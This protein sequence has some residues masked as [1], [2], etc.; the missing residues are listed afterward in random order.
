MLRAPPA[1]HSIR[2]KLSAIVVSAAALVPA[3]VR[4]DSLPAKGRTGEVHIAP[5]QNGRIGAW[6]VVGPFHSA[7]FGDRKKPPTP[8]AL[9][10]PPVGVDESHILPRAGFPIGPT[11]SPTPTPDSTPTPT[12]P[13]TPPPPSPH[14]KPPPLWTLA[15]SN[16]GSIDLQS[17]LHTS[18]PDV[19]AYAAGTLR[20]PRAGRYYILVGADDGVRVY[21]NGRPVFLRD[22]ARPEREDDD[23]IP[24]NLSAGAHPLL[25]KLH[26]R[27][28]GWR[29]GVRVVNAT[30]SAPPGASLVLPGTGPTDARD[31]AAKASWVSLDRG[32]E[33]DGY[34][35]TLTVKFLEG[36]P[37]DVPLRV[38]ATLERAGASAANGGDDARI[39]D[40]DAGQVSLDPPDGGE[41]TVTLPPLVGDDATKLEDGDYVYRVEVAGR[42]LKLPFFARRATREA[43]AHT[44]RAL[45]PYASVPPVWLHE[46]TLDSVV[47]LRDRLAHLVDH[48]DTDDDALKAEARELDD[49]A[50][51][52]ERG[53]DPYEHR[54]GPMRRA[55]RSVADDSLQ[56]FGLY[57]PP[58]VQ[59]HLE[60]AL[61]AHRRSPRAERPPDG[62]ASLVL[63]R[64]RE[65]EGPRLGGS[66]L[67]AAWRRSRANAR[68][69]DDRSGGRG[70]VRGDAGAR[71]S[72]RSTSVTRCVR[73]DP[74]RPRQRDV[75]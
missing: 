9:S 45:A 6:L 23:M 5:A 58:R 48:G 25:F 24:L 10:Q 30:L 18:E 53:T 28:G 70:P 33:G 65:G 59:P 36:A 62:D 22:E 55:Y 42:T 13:S 52:L 54:T 14:S 69:S 60:E 17:L 72:A 20:I 2:V 50:T 44:N 16:E 57:V 41:L 8:E 51:A 32:L 40:V 11:L 49:A 75:P 38:H 29:F 19:I 15:S 27:D 43:I 64:R 71:R 37:R 4:A 61:A 39:F 34:H 12:P 74:R 35:P 68:R 73:R 47:N 56:E 46:G 1:W 31:L 63:R 66:S 21:V 26:Q 7:T 67:D 3:L